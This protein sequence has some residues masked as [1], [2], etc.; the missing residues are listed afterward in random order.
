MPGIVGL[1]TKGP[2]ERAREELRQMVKTIRYEPFYTVGTWA[3]EDMG[4]YVGWTALPNS[5]SAYMPVASENGNVHLFFSGEDF[6]RRGIGHVTTGSNGVTPSGASYLVDLYQSDPSFPASLDGM[7]HGLVVDRAGASATLFNDRYGMYRMYYHEA[8]EG[9]YFAAEAKAILAV[10]PELRKADL[11][12]LGEFIACS[13]VLQD[14]TLFEGIYRLPGGSIW[15]FRNGSL[16]RKSAYF[17]AR[18]WEE[19]PSLHSDA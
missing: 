2:R 8:R 14:R 4:V 9:F 18:E 16:E 12:S 11:R 10:R 13:C 1:I 6:S 5:F 3:H 19:Q 7:F 15:R 17:R